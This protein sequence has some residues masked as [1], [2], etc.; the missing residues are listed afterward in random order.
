V[1]RVLV[2]SCL[3]GE[4]VRYHGGDAR[5]RSTVLD[6]WVAEGRVIPFCPELAGGLGVPRPPAEI[7]GAGGLAVLERRARVMA[8]DGDDVT[9]EFIAG[10]HAALTAAQSGGAVLAILVDG[11]PSCGSR[12]IY[13]GTFSGRRIEGQGVTATLLEREGLPVFSPDRLEAAAKYL[14]SC[15]RDGRG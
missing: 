2:S 6:D 10:A 8:N 5:L 12:E 14:A 7:R 4:R 11:S 1:L 15:E 13:D 3:L 9:E